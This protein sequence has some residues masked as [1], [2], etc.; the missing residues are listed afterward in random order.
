MNIVR[1]TCITLVL[2]LSAA[3]A[4]Q[5]SQISGELK[6]W[7]RVTLTFD[8]PETGEN[9]QPNPFLF[10][11][12]NVIFTHPKTGKTYLVPGYYAADGNAADSSAETGNKWRAHFAPD[13]TGQWK[14]AVSFRQ[15]E[16]IAVSD[17][18]DAGQSAGYMDGQTGTVVINGTDKTGR[19]LRGKGRLKY[20]GKHYLQFADSGEFFM[21]QG[22][23]SPEN[24]LAYDGFDGNFK[25]DNVAL[26]DGGSSDALIKTWNG[27]I[28]DWNTG[29]PTWQNGKGKGIIGAINYLA[30]EGMNAFSFLTL[31]ILGDDKNV[32]PYTSYDERYRMDC[33]RLDQWEIVFSHG[34]KMGMYLHFKMSENENYN[35]LD[36]GDTGPQRKLYC[37]ELIARFSHNLALNW[38]IG[39]ENGQ[40]PEQVQAMAQY[41]H[42]QDPYDHHI[43][44]HTHPGSLGRYNAHVGNQSKLT[45]ASIQSQWKKV[46]SSVS[47]VRQKSINA[48]KL[49]VV[50]SDEQGPGIK[51]DADD[52]NHDAHRKACIWGS[53]MVGGAGS[54]YYF[55]WPYAHSDMTCEDF[56]SRDRW[57]DYCRYALEF[58]HKNNIPFQEMEPDNSLTSSGWCLARPG[59]VYI[60]HLENGGSANLTI[61]SGTYLIRWFDPRNGGSLKT[62]NVTQIT[63]SGARSIG[64]PP[65]NASSDW[66][67]LVR[68]KNKGKIDEM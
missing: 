21:K 15:G 58:L 12:L 66:I 53:I 31:N 45:G 4:V 18:A 2:M 24:F 28:G 19:D 54:E 13:E 55:G 9:A 51:P 57:W 49:W 59:E 23:D 68:R 29:D 63:G 3:V 46:R 67:V 20:V 65:N 36:N 8:G 1:Q 33:S 30:S 42:D 22:A 43:V 6:K 14:Y 34:T 52:P 32:F 38:N 10:Y 56:R 17:D 61:G 50:A 41:I 5:A 37:R 64:S 16:N 7:H 27:H 39:E 47:H 35:L 48:G 40:A 44:M 11:R 25:T 26:K 62:G 60:V